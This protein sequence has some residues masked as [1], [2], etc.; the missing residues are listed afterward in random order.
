MA[1]AQFECPHCQNIIMALPAKAS[2]VTF[3]HTNPALEIQ[4]E[5]RQT[6]IEKK[7]FWASDGVTY[8]LAG[9]FAGGIA[10]LVMWL[11]EWPVVPAVIIGFMVGVGLHVLKILTH[12]PA[13]PAAPS[14]PKTKKIKIEVEAWSEDKR[15]AILNEL[16]ERITLADLKKAA[17]AAIL[18][19]PQ[20][21]ISREGLTSLGL[22]Q[23]KARLILNELKR[24]NFAHTNAQ[25]RTILS[26][27][28][29]A[30]LRKVS[31]LPS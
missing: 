21:I 31:T 25:N 22:S 6:V 10:W 1:S 3:Q 30:F 11:V 20:T 15:H 19:G 5:E 7:S 2:S 18:T 16:D 4:P 17:Q 13:R 26:L 24:L 27:R 9:L 14:Q 12:A 28:G 8:S 29:Q 23:P